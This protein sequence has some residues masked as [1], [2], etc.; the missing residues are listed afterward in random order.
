MRLSDYFVSSLTVTQTHS[1]ALSC[2]DP[3]SSSSPD[4]L[5]SALSERIV[6]H[7]CRGCP[8]L[9]QAW[10]QCAA[11]GHQPS[12]STR[13]A[14]V[15]G[16]IGPVFG[17][18]D[19]PDLVPL[20]HLEGFVSQLLWYFLYAECPPEELVHIEPPGFRPTDP[21]GDALAIHRVQSEYLMFRLWEIKKY[22]GDAESSTGVGSAVNTAYSQL[23]AK[24]I[25]YLARYT[26]IGQ[27]LSDPILQEFYGQLVDLWV[28]ARRE[29]AA[30]VSVVT[31][32]CH[33]PAQCFTTLG[34]RFP[35]YVDPVRLR[36]ML[37]AIGDFSTFCLRVRE[38]VWNG[39]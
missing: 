32:L 17:L 18:P 29:A 24:A 39:I 10:K 13:E 38:F 33:V 23:D 6:E 9:Y 3:S 26:V 36:G 31:S 12:G 30:G 35:R 27:E 34:Q 8:H 19:K 7:L 20:D 4:A 14:L 5:A 21:G 25:E 22:T 15:K 16:F 28:D 1:W 2:H 11:G 37:T